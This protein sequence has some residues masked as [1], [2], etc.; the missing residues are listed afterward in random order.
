MGVAKT[1]LALLA[2]NNQFAQLPDAAVAVS[3]DI[4][5]EAWVYAN[6]TPT[7]WARIFD[8]G[9]GQANNNLILGFDGGKLS[10]VSYVGANSVGQTTVSSSFVPHL[11]THVA[12]T[13]GSIVAPAST[14]PVNLYVNGMQV[15]SGRLLPTSRP[16]R[17]TIPTLATA[18]GRTPIST[19]PSAMPAFMTMPA[20]QH[21]SPPI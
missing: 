7:Q 16:P 12:V 3:G 11:W 13:V 19:A 8:L 4:T 17:A 18:T 20:R 6:G 1:G 5:L 10:F 21:K 2:S 15:A 14:A 9:L